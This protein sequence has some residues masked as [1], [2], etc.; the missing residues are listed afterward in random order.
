VLSNPIL[1]R[2]NRPK[3]GALFRVLVN[4]LQSETFRR[5]NSG[6]G[7]WV[8][9]C[10]DFCLCRWWLTLR[11]VYRTNKSEDSFSVVGAIG[12]GKL[13]A[14]ELARRVNKKVLACFVS[15]GLSTCRATGDRF[16]SSLADFF[17]AGK[18][19]RLAAFG[20]VDAHGLPPLDYAGHV[21]LDETGAT[22]PARQRHAAEVPGMGQPINRP[23]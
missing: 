22:G 14:T 1:R 3:Q 9:P 16:V 8:C 7:L 12:T 4:G 21:A 11:F 15:A 19:K 13:D 23:R 17:Q 5:A 18:V 10:S 2:R 6:G 20:R